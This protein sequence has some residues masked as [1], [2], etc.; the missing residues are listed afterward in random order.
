MIRNAAILLMIG[1]CGCATSHTEMSLAH[2]INIPKEWSTGSESP[3]F[4]E[5][6]PIQRYARAYDEAW[7]M[8]IGE[9]AKDIHYV[10][11]PIYATS[12]WPEE[13]AGASAGYCDACDRVDL[14]LK[15]YGEGRVVDFLK[16]FKAADVARKGNL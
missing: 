10:R 3:V 1:L 12:G 6:A 2:A 16:Q 9:Y 4:S 13:A 14:L 8:A 5:S 7:W 11:M 15:K